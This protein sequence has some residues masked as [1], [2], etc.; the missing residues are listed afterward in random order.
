MVALAI[1]LA[2]VRL[3]SAAPV[4]PPLTPQDWGTGG[5]LEG[6]TLA[7]PDA[8]TISS[9][10][11]GGNPD[12]Y[13]LTTFNTPGVPAPES[14]TIQSTE[15][16]YT[17]DLTGLKLTFDF[18]GYPPSDQFFTFTSTFGGGSTWEIPFS[19]LASQTWE[20]KMFSFSGPSGWSLVSGSGTFLDA[21]MSV[22]L[23]GVNVNHVPL[24]G[25][26]P[27]TYGIDNW[28]Y[29]INASTADLPEPSQYLMM[30][31]VLLSTTLLIHQRRNGVIPVAAE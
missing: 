31:M 28:Q 21:V 11:S 30:L 3:A 6:F 13:L 8:D 10:G 17:G 26:D 27:F 23:V 2:C 16:N 18:L 15:T 1:V 9:P 25:G 5:D 12:G 22:T 20:T 7:G 4:M 14:D 24:I 29:M 19:S